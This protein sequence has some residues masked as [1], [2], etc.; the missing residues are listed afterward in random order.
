MKTRVAQVAAV[1]AIAI[2]LAGLL[3]LLCGCAEDQARSAANIRVL[4]LRTAQAGPLNA[5]QMVLL[6]GVLCEADAIRTS[7]SPEAQPTIAPEM[8]HQQAGAEAKAH[9]QTVRT[10][11]DQVASSVWTWVWGAAGGVS[12]HL[13][14]GGAVR[15]LGPQGGAILRTAVQF[16]SAAMDALKRVNKPAANAVIEEQIQVQ[17]ERGHRQQLREVRD[18]VKAAI[19]PQT[20]LDELEKEKQARLDAE[21]RLALTEK[22]AHKMSAEYKRL[23]AQVEAENA[24]EPKTASDP[25]PL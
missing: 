18:E 8:T 11:P 12:A 24:L 6:E 3:C 1:I 4:T 16:G 23:W 2:A 9:A 25:K 20:L 22:A 7:T 17:E 19:L 13:L 10:L 14:G 21:D 5:D 15:L